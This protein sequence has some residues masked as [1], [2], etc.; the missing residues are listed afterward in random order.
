MFLYRFFICFF[1]NFAEILEIC[2]LD[3][4]DAIFIGFRIQHNVNYPNTP[5]RDLKPLSSQHA[6]SLVGHSINKI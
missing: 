6:V 2:E 3:S 5:N 1:F 4:K